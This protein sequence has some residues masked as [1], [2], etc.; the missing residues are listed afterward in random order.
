MGQYRSRIKEEFSE[1]DL[2]FLHGLIESPYFDNNND[3][4]DA[5][6]YRFKA[7]DF[8]E[9][10]PATNRFALLKG[11]YVFKF[12]LDDYGIKDNINEFEMS[13]ELQPYVT[14]TYE[15]NGLITIA[16][17]VNL[18]K[19]KEFVE[20]IPHIKEILLQ[21][22]ENYL[23]SDIG[24]ITKNFCNYGFRDDDSIVILDYGYI[25]KKDPNI[26]YCDGCGGRLEYTENFDSLY[27]VKCHRKHRVWDVVHQMRI[28][29]E[30][31]QN[32][33]KIK[34]PLRIGLGNN[35]KVR[36]DE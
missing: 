8:V 29:D 11:K 13:M 9:L 27:C 30:E 24:T 12:A 4:A 3:K 10:A 7:K 23:F 28:S 1:E 21:L 25:Y 15:T 22:S 20:S 14:K 33:P 31:Y 36:D 5:I 18:I 35:K 32:I 26:M 34:G 6:L 17:Y 16:E 19:E 2:D